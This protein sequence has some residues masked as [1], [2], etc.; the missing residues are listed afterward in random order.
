MNYHII[1]NDFCPA[2]LNPQYPNSASPTC[3]LGNL[4]YT[5]ILYILYG[6]LAC[7]NCLAIYGCQRVTSFSWTRNIAKA[8]KND[9]A[10]HPDN[11]N[12]DVSSVWKVAFIKEAYSFLENMI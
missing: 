8:D 6:N 1:M 10:A 5:F 4:F 3:V 2:G 9:K 7:T 11:L 12:R